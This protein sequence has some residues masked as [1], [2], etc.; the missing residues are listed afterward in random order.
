VR[1]IGINTQTKTLWSTSPIRDHVTNRVVKTDSGSLYGLTGAMDRQKALQYFPAS[2]LDQFNDGF[3]S[4]WHSKLYAYI[5]KGRV[6]SEDRPINP[7]AADEVESEKQKPLSREVVNLL[8][9]RK[10][11]P[12][13]SKSPKSKSE[14]SAEK[15]MIIPEVKP[16]ELTPRRR[17]KRLQDL[18]DESLDQDDA[19]AA[20]K[21]RKLSESAKSVEKTKSKAESKS[22]TKAEAKAETKAETKSETKAATVASSSLFSMPSQSKATS[23]TSSTP[24]ASDA[25]IKTAN[26]LFSMFAAAPSAKSPGVVKPVKV[27][28]KGTDKPKTSSLFAMFAK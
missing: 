10:T 5:S 6:L 18:D 11:K 2:I 3:P 20:P 14:S 4:D 26:S 24:T 21:Q 27:A 23:K 25:H 9:T 7:D 16:A 22:A 13:A 19:P 17:L 12:Q 1:L 15:V 28:E 8:T